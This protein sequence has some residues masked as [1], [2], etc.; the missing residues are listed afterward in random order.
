MTIAVEFKPRGVYDYTKVEWKRERIELLAVHEH[1]D[2]EVAVLHVPDGKLS[3]FVSRAT[4]YL[5]ENNPQGTGPKHA[6][7][8]NAIENIRRAAFSELWSDTAKPPEDDESHWFQIWLRH[9]S[10]EIQDLVADFT[11]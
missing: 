7:L 1:R 9:T 6:S 5:R 3:A 4:E 11:V 2:R 8:V 10:G